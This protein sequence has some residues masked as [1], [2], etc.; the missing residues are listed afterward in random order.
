MIRETLRNL[1]E[2]LGDTY[3]R[4]LTKISKS[5]SRALAQKV[6]KWAAVAK[7]PLHVEELREAVAIEPDDKSW[8]EDKIPHEDLM[9]ECCRG[10]II[11]DDDET[12]HFAH[13]TVQQYLT[14]GLATKVDPLF[15]ISVVNADILA[16]QTCIAYL[17]FS[18]FETQITSTTP[19]VT[20]EQK[21][22]LKSGGPLWIPSILGIR[23]PMFD[24]P[25]RL[26]RGDP[27]MG[28]S[29]SDYW[30]H[31]RPKPKQKQ[32]PSPDLKYKYRLLCYAIEYWEPHTR[33]YQLSDS[34]SRRRLENLAKHKS[35]AFDF[36]P[37]GSN[38]HFGSYGCVGCPRPPSPSEACLVAKDLPHMPMIH[39]AAEVGNLPLLVSHYS[40]EIEIRDYID[41]ERY[42]DETLLIACR[43]NRIEI[44]RYL[45]KRYKS[46]Y[47]GERAV[48]AAAT[49]GHAKVVQYLISL[50]EYPVKQIDDVPL[51]LAAKNGHDAVVRVLAEAGANINAYDQQ[52]RRSIIES[53]AVNGH[54]SVIRILGAQQFLDRNLE[55]K[56]LHLAAANGH[57]TVTRVL[58]ESSLSNDETGVGRHLALSEAAKSGH[59]AVAELLLEYG[60]DPS[61]DRLLGNLADY[62]ETPFHLAAKGG[63]AKVLELFK[64]YVTLVDFR[65]TRSRRTAL[66]CAA[67]GGHEKAIR[68]LL[69]NGADVNAKDRNGETPLDYASKLGDETAAR[70]LLELGAIVVGTETAHRHLLRQAVWRAKGGNIT[71][72]GLLLEHIRADR[73]TPREE[74]RS[75]ILEALEYA[76]DLSSVEAVEMLERELELYSE[77]KINNNIQ[78]IC[79]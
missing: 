66:H 58:L 18:D 72:L 33:S 74:R 70:A 21:G 34:V 62:Y 19:T 76:R 71:V 22:V 69:E 52:T 67:I 57:V 56:A 27:A 20:L 79:I 12:A 25:Y 73:Q 16:G 2:G 42:H 39:Y 61:F 54:V 40:S 47:L 6:F 50:R 24:I 35:L 48:I 43:H 65:A 26:L 11:K 32:S 15:E 77:E 75:A 44:V 8:N 59:S 13:H 53:A 31:L 7:R 55:M 3:K 60:A 14:G 63:H 23:R 45:M 29:D 41:H 28:P 37:W 4:I 64:T 30:K 5:L 17:S 1:P 36:R 38:Q 68:W 78:D 10:L 9:F 49:A 46:S 51:L